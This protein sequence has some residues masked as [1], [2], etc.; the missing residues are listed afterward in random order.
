MIIYFVLIGYVLVLPL[1]VRLFTSNSTKIQTFVALFGMLGVYL[2][3]A[4]K[5]PTVGIDIAG[6]SEQYYI[7]KTVPWS[8]FDYVYF[9][10]GYILLEKVFSK[11]GFSFQAFTMIL[12]G[13]ECSAWYLLIKKQ[14]SNA[15]ISVLFFICYQFFVLSASGLRQALAMSV[16]IFAYL[17]FLKQSPR[18]I[19]FGMFLVG[20]AYSIH[21]SALFFLIIPV[22]IFLSSRF[23]RIHVTGIAAVLLISGIARQAFW[24]FVNNYMKEVDVSASV[25]LG[26][27]FMLL[28][29]IMLFSV[30]TYNTYYHIGALGNHNLNVHSEKIEYIDTLEVW[31]SVVSVA[32]FILLSGGKML[33]ASMYISMLIVPLFPNLIEKYRREYRIIIKV[34]FIVFL[35]ILFYRET[36][37]VNQLRIS[38][39]KFFWQM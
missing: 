15:M 11:I 1:I 8:N 32:S 35:I 25:S 17:L 3:L 18:R 30:F 29:G 24:G 2:V 33:R 7:A 27:S 28:A 16:C 26:G 31:I 9:E 13:V 23:P 6:Y 34:V 5:A 36:L 14:S 21:S 38:H 19:V 10:K 4:L 39:Y 22:L 37:V 12:Y 20:V